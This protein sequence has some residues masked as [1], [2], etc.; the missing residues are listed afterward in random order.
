MVDIKQL[1]LDANDDESDEFKEGWNS[2]VGY[3]NDNYCITTRSGEPISI[4]FDIELDYE[5][6]IEKIA[7]V[8]KCKK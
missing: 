7:K 3:I 8:L 4:K 1:M 5:T 6:L 2:A